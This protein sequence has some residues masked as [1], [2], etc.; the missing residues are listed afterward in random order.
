MKIATWNIERLKHKRAL[1]EII[2]ACNRLNA[3][4]LVLTETDEQVE[5]NFS[6]SICTPTPPEII[7]PKYPEPLRYK[8]TEHRIAIYS[9]YRFVQQHSTY[10]RFTALCVELET[11]IG[12]LLIYGSIM[13]VQGNRRPSYQADI[14][15]Q[16]ADIRRLSKETRKLCVCGDFNC[17]FAD[18]Y[19]FTNEGRAAL[20][21]GLEDSRMA[22]LTE[23]QSECVDHIAISQDLLGGYSVEIEEW[24]QDKQ[25]SDHKGISVRL[26]R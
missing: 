12:N 3:D 20:R 8:P 16:M 5:P 24:N 14:V 26:Y 21:N 2:D 15:A 7:L 18:N 4:I 23:A 22:L 13:G 9:N 19:Y 17:S 10:D 25:L 11:E 1:S 6:F